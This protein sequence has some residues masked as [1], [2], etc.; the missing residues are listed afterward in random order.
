MQLP[1]PDG[2]GTGE[3]LFRADK[4]IMEFRQKRRELRRQLVGEPGRLLGAAPP[5]FN[6]P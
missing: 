1:K 4:P 3:Q 2:I 6:G 5:V